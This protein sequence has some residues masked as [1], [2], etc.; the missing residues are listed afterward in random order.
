M[1]KEIRFGPS[2]EDYADTTVFENVIHI[3]EEDDIAV[4]FGPNR[5]GKSTMIRAIENTMDLFMGVDSNGWKE[6]D[7]GIEPPY[8]MEFIDEF[9]IRNVGITTNIFRPLG[10]EDKPLVELIESLA[11]RRFS[12]LDKRTLWSCNVLMLESGVSN[13]IPI[14]LQSEDWNHHRL[15]DDGKGELVFIDLRGASIK[16]TAKLDV[17]HWYHSGNQDMVNVEIA[18]VEWPMFWADGSPGWL[19]TNSGS[20]NQQPFNIDK[21]CIEDIFAFSGFQTPLGVFHHFASNPRER[22]AT[23]AL[24]NVIFDENKFAANPAVKASLAKKDVPIEKRKKTELVA[25]LRALDDVLSEQELFQE[26][27]FPW[28]SNIEESILQSLSHIPGKTSGNK[29]SLLAQIKTRFRNYIYLSSDTSIFDPESGGSFADRFEWNVESEIIL[30]GK[31]EDESRKIIRAIFGFCSD[32]EESIAEAT[33]FDMVLDEEDYP[34]KAEELLEAGL[35]FPSS[36]GDEGMQKVFMAL[37]ELLP[38]R[39]SIMNTN[40]FFEGSDFK[41]SFTQ[42]GFSLIYGSFML[43]FCNRNNLLW[44]ETISKTSSMIIFDNGKTG[45]TRFGPRDIPSIWHSSDFV[46]GRKYLR[47]D[48]DRVSGFDEVGSALGDSPLASKEASGGLNSKLSSFSRALRSDGNV[49]KLTEHMMGLLA[50]VSSDAKKKHQEYWHVG[51][52]WPADYYDYDK[53]LC[54]PRSS[55][56]EDMCLREMLEGAETLLHQGLIETHNGILNKI[57]SVY[58]SIKSQEG[59][60]GYYPDRYHLRKDVAWGDY[61]GEEIDLIYEFRD[62]VNKLS[63]ALDFIQ[64]ASEITDIRLQI[65]R[66]GECKFHWDGDQHVGLSSGEKHI[67]A[68]LIPIA[69]L[70]LENWDQTGDILVMIDE[71]EVSLHV[72]WQ[73]ELYRHLATILKKIRN[74]PESPRVKVVLSTHSPE[75]IGCHDGGSQRFGPKEEEYEP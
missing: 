29:E 75:F 66:E 7:I 40:N 60:G 27:V 42:N 54:T 73:R 37:K 38:H 47:L 34:E 10:W 23:R 22:G 67:F 6:A 55:S 28:V 26:V 30:P 5:S 50:H 18:G 68:M 13:P 21:G 32:K 69:T 41:D 74:V 17:F 53:T 8:K 20:V 3:P 58:S 11:D 59:K 44:G 49:S 62:T 1:S 45:L 65:N 19:K 61:E 51:A 64:A 70:I 63:C 24:L 35:R 48:V 33:L 56:D 25:I 71:P 36:I 52:E 9:K 14:D 2:S 46:L 15:S 43:N 39:F 16:M 4:V 72:K 57:H 12:T 31:S